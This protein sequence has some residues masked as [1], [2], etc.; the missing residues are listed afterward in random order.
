MM[1]SGW[2]VDVDYSNGED[3]D[4]EN[5]QKQHCTSNTFYGYKVGYQVGRVSTILKGS[6]KIILTYGTCY[7]DASG[8]VSVSLN[9]IKIDETYLNSKVISFQY[10][11]GDFLEIKELKV[12]VIQLYELILLDGGN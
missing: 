4:N 3:K 1:R 9:G 7:D 2:N 6:G 5:L 11:K 10:R 8:H 12:A